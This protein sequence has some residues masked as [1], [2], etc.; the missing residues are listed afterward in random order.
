MANVNKNDKKEDIQKESESDIEL[1][2]GDNESINQK[3]KCLFCHCSFFRKRVLRLVVREYSLYVTILLIRLQI[4]EGSVILGKKQ[5]VNYL[6]LNKNQ[7]GFYPSEDDFASISKE[8]CKKPGMRNN[9]IDRIERDD[10]PNRLERFRRYFV[11][12]LSIFRCNTRNE[13]ENDS[14]INDYGIIDSFLFRLAKILDIEIRSLE[15][16]I[17]HVITSYDEIL[18]DI[19]VQKLT[20]ASARSEEAIESMI[21][22]TFWQPKALTTLEKKINRHDNSK[23]DS[24][25]DDSWFEAVDRGCVVPFYSSA[26]ASWFGNSS[27]DQSSK[28][29]LNRCVH[30]IEEN[31]LNAFSWYLDEYFYHDFVF[32]RNIYSYEQYLNCQKLQKI[33]NP[34][35]IVDKTNP[36]ELGIPFAHVITL[37]FYSY[38][39]Y[40]RNYMRE[41]HLLSNSIIRINKNIPF[42]VRS[43]NPITGTHIFHIVYKRNYSTPPTYENLFKGLVLLRDAML[44]LKLKDLA[45]CKI[46]CYCERLDFDKVIRMTEFVFLNT[47]INVRIGLNLTKCCQ[48]KSR[49]VK[50][51]HDE[52]VDLHSERIKRYFPCDTH[53]ISKTDVH[54]ND[55]D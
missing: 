34:K 33:C 4:L 21:I 5:T 46:G 47:D 51:D 52:Y 6:K 42:I 38:H 40:V 19:N 53:D 31:S 32:P 37:N 8:A 14:V 41:I 2:Y 43:L 7:R 3:K 30:E 29:L 26:H 50:Y 1:T 44:R 22:D 18:L 20:R 27:A 45:M 17:D 24:G 23:H 39:K 28:S 9:R 54:S 12:S 15:A 35:V 49:S 55:K 36:L 10:E 11:R 25:N 16:C 13:D 48:F